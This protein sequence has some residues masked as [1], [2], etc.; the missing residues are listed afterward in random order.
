MRTLTLTHA[1]WEIDEEKLLGSPG[2]YGAVF[3]G[4]NEMGTPVAIKLLKTVDDHARELEFA[5][6]FCGKSTKHIVPILDHGVDAATGRPCVVM[7][8]AERNLRTKLHEVAAFSESDAL[9]ILID[10]GLGLTEAASWV[11]RDLKPENSLLYDG[12]WHLADFGLARQADAATATHTVRGGMTMQYAAPEQITGGHTTNATDVYA[13]GCIGAELLSGK[14][15]FPEPGSALRHLTG[16][17][18]IEKASPQLHK[19]L[20]DMMGKEPASRPD[21]ATVLAELES[22][23]TPRT[24]TGEGSVRLRDAVTRHLSAVARAAAEHVDRQTREEHRAQVAQAARIELEGFAIRLFDVL[25]ESAPNANCKCPPSISLPTSPL[26]R[27]QRPVHGQQAPQ[28][29]IVGTLA[30]KFYAQFGSGH[31]AQT[32]GMFGGQPESQF[33]PDWN[34]YTGDVI[35]VWQSDQCWSASLWYASVKGAKPRWYE[36][37]Y[38]H[39]HMPGYFPAALRPGTEAT[40][41]LSNSGQAGWQLAYPPREVT[42]NSID[43]FVDRWLNLFADAVD[44]A[45]KAPQPLPLTI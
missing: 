17:P 45:L 29:P 2:G 1:T 42:G 5:A 39:P 32:M 14:F 19:L 34:V 40:T 11:H 37:G 6:F 18:H 28:S 9:S 38:F 44:H 10:L 41:A 33:G 4:R 31:L 3:A 25:Y 21:V 36:I 43:D 23:R 22:I 24:H 13:L 20:L 12:R 7:A 26:Q 30:P 35:A 15:A 8:Q 16:S 27:Q